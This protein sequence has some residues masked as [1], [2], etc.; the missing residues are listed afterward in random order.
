MSAAEANTRRRFPGLDA[1]ALQ[2]PFD[3]VALNA[4]QQIP[5][6]DVVMR[7]FIELFPERIAYIQ[8][9]AQTVRVTNARNAPNCMCNCRKHVPFSICPNRNSMSRIIR[10]P[11]PGQAAIITPTSLLP[12]ACSI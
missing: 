4:L 6:L 9:V 11:M 12:A 2:H 10:C 5:G 1:V 8:N 7:K 3:R